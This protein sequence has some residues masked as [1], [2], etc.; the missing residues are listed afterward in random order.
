M[1]EF[2]IVV[3]LLI[4]LVLGFVE[5]GRALYQHNTLHEALAAGPRYLGRV[6][7]IIDMDPGANSC[8]WDDP[9]NTARNNATNLVVYGALAAGTPVLEGFEISD[10]TVVNPPE[11][12]EYVVG[13]VIQFSACIIRM[14]ADVSF[15]PL[16]GELIPIPA[17]LS[18][19][20]EERYIAE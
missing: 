18:A 13:G 7:G 14:E 12:Y 11:Y 20:A 17:S 2:A 5:L 4:I 6:P 10:I 16:F 1:V 9:S 3:W 8:S 19:A 15:S